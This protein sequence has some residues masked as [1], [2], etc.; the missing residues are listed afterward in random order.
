M[1]NSRA[2]TA[3][4]VRVTIEFFDE[5]AGQWVNTV[6]V[7]ENIIDASWQA[8]TDAL[9]SKLLMQEDHA[10]GGPKRVAVATSPKD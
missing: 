4:K 1:V 8:L 5:Q 7:N 6:G 2:G 10:N 9:E 3:A